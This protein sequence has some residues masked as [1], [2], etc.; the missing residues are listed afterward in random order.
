MAPR[1][2]LVYFFF[3]H[4]SALS[5]HLIHWLQAF[6]NWLKILRVIQILEF[7]PVKSYNAD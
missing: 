5:A 3:L 7:F 1:D 4:Q 2:L 6:P